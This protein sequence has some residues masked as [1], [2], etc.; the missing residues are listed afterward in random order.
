[1]LPEK[2]L[3]N[4]PGGIGILAAR[5]GDEIHSGLQGQEPEELQC[6]LKTTLDGVFDPLL[7][8]FT[9]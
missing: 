6:I 5:K 2:K 3:R 4:A 9:Q 7:H 8:F 1:M